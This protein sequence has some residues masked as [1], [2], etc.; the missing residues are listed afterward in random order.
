M[1]FLST[2]LFSPQLSVCPI[3]SDAPAASAS[4]SSSSATPS[5]TVLMGLMNSCVV[6]GFRQSLGEVG[7]D[8]EVGWGCGA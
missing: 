4:S 2:A 8:V 5:L 7:S 1:A 3:S 6:S